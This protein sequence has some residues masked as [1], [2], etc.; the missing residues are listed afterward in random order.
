MAE[1]QLHGLG[2]I[3]VNTGK[4][5]VMLHTTLRAAALAASVA[6]VNK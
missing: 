3:V 4:V 5:V 1:E 2:V 6:A